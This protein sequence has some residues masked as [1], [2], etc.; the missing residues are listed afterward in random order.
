MVTARSPGVRCHEYRGHNLSFHH[1]TLSVYETHQIPVLKCDQDH[2]KDNIRLMKTFRIDFILLSVS[3]RITAYITA[4][5]RRRGR[6]RPGV[7]KHFTIEVS[8]VRF[9]ANTT[10]DQQDQQPCIIDCWFRIYVI[11]PELF[12]WESWL[13]VDCRVS[14]WQ[15]SEN[16]CQLSIVSLIYTLNLINWNKDGWS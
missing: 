2:Q 8:S 7:N 9:H 10:P 15:G 13:I 5:Q 6:V 11:G 1:Q 3:A 12:A 14:S 4:A 16:L